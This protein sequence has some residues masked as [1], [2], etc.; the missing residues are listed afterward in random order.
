M[1]LI[2]RQLTRKCGRGNENVNSLFGKKVDITKLHLKIVRI[3]GFTE[4]SSCE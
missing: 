2:L 1:F 4:T 3:P